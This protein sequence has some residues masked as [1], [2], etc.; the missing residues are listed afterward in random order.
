MKG[1]DGDG[2][3]GGMEA[4]VA[5]LEADMDHVKK[6]VDRLIAGTDD[7]KKSLGDIKV[8]LAGIDERTKP[9]PTKWDVFLILVA[10][11]GVLATVITIAARF[12][13]K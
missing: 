6:G 11:L 1:G 8:T 4:R 3:S 13:A 12:L 2:T 5:K 9:L 10:T 7:I